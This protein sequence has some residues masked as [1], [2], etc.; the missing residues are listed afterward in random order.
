MSNPYSEGRRIVWTHGHNPERPG[1]V[2]E[3]LDKKHVAVVF[4]DCPHRQFEIN[5]NSPFLR[6][7]SVLDQLADLAE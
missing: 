6:H 7:I 2:V 1:R 5:V 3:V 4:D